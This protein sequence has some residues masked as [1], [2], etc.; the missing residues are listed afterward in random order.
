MLFQYA[1]IWFIPCKTWNLEATYM[2]STNIA[3]M[4]QAIWF[5]SRLLGKDPFSIAS[6]LW[7]LA[8]ITESVVCLQC[9]RLFCT[10]LKHR[11]VL[12]CPKRGSSFLCPDDFIWRMVC[13][14]SCLTSNYYCKTAKCIRILSTSVDSTLNPR[15]LYFHLNQKQTPFML[16][17]E[18]L[19]LWGMCL[20]CNQCSL[21]GQ[22]RVALLSA[23]LPT[24]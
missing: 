11:I 21:K 16:N 15:L 3:S 6:V 2:V 22:V 9:S 13:F 20:L 24:L 10:A 1:L 14:F 23:R 4:C 17:T 5:V 8:V 19:V 18:W 7:R 12:Y